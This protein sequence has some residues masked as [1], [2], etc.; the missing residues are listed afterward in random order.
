LSVLNW[1]KQKLVNAPATLS[2]I[3][4][5]AWRPNPEIGYGELCFATPL[6]AGFWSATGALYTQFRQSASETTALSWSPTGTE[7]ARGHGQ[8]KLDIRTPS[9][10]RIL[11]LVSAAEHPFRMVAWSCNG[12]IVAAS[13]LE[14]IFAWKV[15]GAR[16]GMMCAAFS[17][18][19][20]SPI[21][22]NRLPSGW[23]YPR[24]RRDRWSSAPLSTCQPGRDIALRFF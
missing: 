21:F 17:R 23:K 2:A 7:V 20:H 18:N 19:L 16:H 6:G 11:D 1:E 10:N 14:S 3:Q 12:R 9:A 15:D 24:R 5:I 4:R 8:G 13:S 22:S